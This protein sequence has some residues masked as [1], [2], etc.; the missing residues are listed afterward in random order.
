MSLLE[1]LKKSQSGEYINTKIYEGERIIT[2]SLLKNY[3]EF[4][5]SVMN[6]SNDEKIK[7]LKQISENTKKKI[8][9]L[10]GNNTKHKLKYIKK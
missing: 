5:E 3:D 10:P 4:K 6:F 9:R 1:Q 2:K 7:L 8:K